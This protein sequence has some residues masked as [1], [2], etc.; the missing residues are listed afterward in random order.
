MFDQVG[1]LGSGRLFKDHRPDLIRVIYHLDAPTLFEVEGAFDARSS[2]PTVPGP[3]PEVHL[4][5][6]HF[7]TKPDQAVGPDNVY[8][9]LWC[10][11]AFLFIKFV[12][13]KAAENED[14]NDDH[15]VF[16]IGPR[17]AGASCG[18][19]PL[20]PR[21]KDFVNPHSPACGSRS[22]PSLG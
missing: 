6:E 10:K 4:G 1:G 5:C 21:L 12:V 20:L 13:A 7:S 22:N 17:V 8:N 2:P 14:G 19:M 16:S 9:R 3:A 15:F 18:P 11:Y